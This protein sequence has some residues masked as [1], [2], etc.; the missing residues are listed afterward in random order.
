MNQDQFERELLVLGFKITREV[1]PESTPERYE[2]PDE[3]RDS[4]PL[5]ERFTANA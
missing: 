4:W 3:A 2:A 5:A 1:D